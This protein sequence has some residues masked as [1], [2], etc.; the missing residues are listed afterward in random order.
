[1]CM[2]VPTVMHLTLELFDVLQ[3]S[4]YLFVFEH[5]NILSI[6]YTSQ[7]EK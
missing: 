4:I 5:D 3:S 2:I 7:T 6:Q 1:M